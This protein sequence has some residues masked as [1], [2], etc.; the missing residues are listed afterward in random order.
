MTSRRLATPAL[1]VSLLLVAGCRDREVTAYRAPKDPPPVAM[2][3]AALEGTNNLPSDHP[4]IDAG[5]GGPAAPAP[6]M[7][8]TPV[9]TAGGTGLAWTAPAE[10]TAKALSA[11]RKGSFSVKGYG[12]E[13]DLSITA[14]P[15]NTGGLEANLNRWRGQVGLPAQSP[16]EVTAATEKIDSGNLQFLLVDY[17]NHGSRLVGAIL[18]YDGNTWFFKLLGPDALVARTKPAFLDFLRTV[19][20]A[21]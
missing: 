15:G 21:K 12:G 4:P 13:A 6:A 18:P 17:G 9:P 3:A 14:F 10:W 2:P 1:L 11:M 7:A 19:K 5:G 8:N 16:A 20:P